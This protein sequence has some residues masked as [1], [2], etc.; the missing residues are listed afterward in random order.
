MVDCVVYAR[1]VIPIAT[2]QAARRTPVATICLIAANAPGFTITANTINVTVTRTTGGATVS[3]YVELWHTIE[4]AEPYPGLAP[5]N[6]PFVIDANGGGGGGGSNIIVDNQGVALPNNPF[7][8]LDFTGGG[9]VAADAGAGVATITI[10]GTVT[11]DGTTITGD[12]S[13]GS[14]LA[15]VGGPLPPAGLAGGLWQPL[16]PLL[17]D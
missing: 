6:F 15:V 13:T 4:D 1:A 2:D 3:V 12:G 14:P 16:L 7:T 11:T 17:V 8:T 10:P 5:T 9:V